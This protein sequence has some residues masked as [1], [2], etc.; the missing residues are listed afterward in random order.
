[1]TRNHTHTR[2]LGLISAGLLAASLGMAVQAAEP[3]ARPE[4]GPGMHMQQDLERMQK[5]LN[6][7][8]KQEALFQTARDASRDA[9]REGMASRRENHE[10]MRAALEG[11]NPDLRA[12][13][14]QM[15]KERDEHMQKHRQVRDAWLNFYD[16]LNP[17]QKEKARHFIVARM[18]HMKQAMQERRPGMGRMPDRAPPSGTAPGPR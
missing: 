2:R 3:P 13:A 10:K 6:L 11:P 1:M 9:M 16:A 4:R 7:D 14:A 18:D 15:D 5:D 17:A 8:K 12:L